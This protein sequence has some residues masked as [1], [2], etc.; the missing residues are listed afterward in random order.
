MSSFLDVGIL[1]MP[2]SGGSCLAEAQ[3]F[4]QLLKVSTNKTVQDGFFGC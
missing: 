1:I 4:A 2:V 3:D